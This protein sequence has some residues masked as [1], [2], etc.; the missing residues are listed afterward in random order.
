M[1]VYTN[2]HFFYFITTKLI[3]STNKLIY[4]YRYN[5]A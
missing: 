3:I 5:Y 2:S 1:H 4:I